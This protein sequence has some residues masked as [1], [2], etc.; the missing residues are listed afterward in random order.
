MPSLWKC[1]GLTPLPLVRLALKKIREDELST[2]SAAL[3]HYFR[4]SS[5]KLRGAQWIVCS[6]L[7]TGGAVLDP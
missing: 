2:P 6:L 7:R 5:A 4:R 1:G 3:S